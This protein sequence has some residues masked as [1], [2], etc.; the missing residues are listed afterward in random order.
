MDIELLRRLVRSGRR[1]SRRLVKLPLLCD[2]V[3][4][5]TRT[6]EHSKKWSWVMRSGWS[7]YQVSYRRHSSGVRDLVTRKGKYATT[8]S[9]AMFSGRL[10]S[11]PADWPR[12]VE[13]DWTD[14]GR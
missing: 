12:S 14:G 5:A 9:I 3:R 2:A 7:G 4:D 1:W 13:M 8:H 6:S 10:E 11:D